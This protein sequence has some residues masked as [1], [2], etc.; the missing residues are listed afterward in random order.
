MQTAAADREVLV[1]GLTFRQRSAEGVYRLRLL[2]KETDTRRSTYGYWEAEVIEGGHPA[3]LHQIQ[4]VAEKA[5]HIARSGR[6]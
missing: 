2:R 4:F 6:Y 1:P 3:R 5:V